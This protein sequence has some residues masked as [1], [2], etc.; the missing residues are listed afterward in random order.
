MKKLLVLLVFLSGVTQAGI[1]GIKQDRNFKKHFKKNSAAYEIA[2][3]DK[4]GLVLNIGPKSISCSAKKITKSAPTVGVCLF[5]A[6]NRSKDYI[7]S[8][9]INAEGNPTLILLDQFVRQRM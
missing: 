2:I 4:F 3:E 9:S 1:S 8:S 5:T 7:F 6:S